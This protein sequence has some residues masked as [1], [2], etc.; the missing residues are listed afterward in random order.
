MAVG[1]IFSWGVSGSG[2]RQCLSIALLESDIGGCCPS[3]QT[4]VG[5]LAA[6]C[7]SEE[8]EARSIIALTYTEGETKLV[9][10]P[11]D[12]AW[13]PT[14]C[15]KAIVNRPVMMA[16]DHRLIRPT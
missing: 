6:Q 1:L 4:M 14:R 11:V 12:L 16:E 3:A 10:F 15:E 2:F 9:R 13:S 7:R 5:M 8:A